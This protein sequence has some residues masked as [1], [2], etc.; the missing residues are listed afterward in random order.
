MKINNNKKCIP[1]E[2][3]S[4]YGVFYLQVT[5]LWNCCKPYRMH[6]R[7]ICAKNLEKV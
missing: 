2:E 5:G 3:K 4:T 1:L 6:T 7:V